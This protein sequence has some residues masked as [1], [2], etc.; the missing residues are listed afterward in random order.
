MTG[1]RQE[2]LVE[3]TVGARGSETVAVRHPASGARAGHLGCLCPH[4]LEPA[5]LDYRPPNAVVLGLGFAV[6]A[7]AQALAAGLLPLAAA[8]M[9]PAL[10]GLPY[11][12]L[13]AGAA[14]ATFPASFL[15]DG[16]GRRSGFALGASIGIAGGLLIAAAILQRQFVWLCLGAFW[17]G[18]AQGFGFFYR[19]AAALGREP[20]QGT[21]VVAGVFAAGTIAG[22]AGPTLATFAESLVAPYLFVGVSLLI[23]LAHVGGLAAAVARPAF[24]ARVMPEDLGHERASVL[25]PTLMG[26]TAWFGMSALMVATPLAMAACGIAPGTIFG[27]V[28]WHVVAMYAPAVLL[29]GSVLQS[30]YRAIPVGMACLAVAGVLQAVSGTTAPFTVGLVLAGA[31]WSLVTVATT[32]WLHERRPSRSQLAVHDA[33]LFAAAIAGSV[34]GG[35]AVMRTV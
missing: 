18:I 1:L 17:I 21:A 9:T 26:V 12:A 20:G 11:A 15:L 13:L 30:R 5:P 19:H 8:E 28:A 16:F 34:V 32:A 31:G 3:K 10:A 23:A 29:L 35:L 14:I 4:G 7:L 22:I 6:A 24:P 27:A 25:W 33:L 2:T